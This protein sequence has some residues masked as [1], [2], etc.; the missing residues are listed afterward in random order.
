[1]NITTNRTSCRLTAGA[2]LLAVSAIAS[3]AFA[4]LVNPVPFVTTPPGGPIGFAYAGNKFIGTILDNGTGQNLIYSTDLSGGSVTT[5]A[6]TVTL[7]PTYGLEHYVSASLGGGQGGFPINDVYV[8]SGNNIVHISNNGAINY[9]NFISSSTPLNG[10]VRGITFDATGNWGGNMLVTTLN[11]YVYRVNAT[12]IATQIAYTGEDTEGL[13]VAPLNT[14][15]TGYA[16]QLFV[17]SEGSG[18]IRA[19]KPSNAPG[20]PGTTITSGLTGAEQLSFVPMNLGAS[21]NPLEGMYSANYGVNVLHAPYTDFTTM[22]GDIILTA[23]GLPN[24]GAI[25]QVSPGAIPSVTT[26]GLIPNQPEDGVFVTADM[27]NSPEPASLLLL[28]LAAPA[29]LIRRR[30]RA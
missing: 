24:N 3:P 17:A 9:G 19:I 5:F 29:L 11:G 4:A 15:W 6:P 23:E 2:V 1:M 26:V 22:L 20:S 8:A 28:T 13:D 25:W 10:D 21:G 12:G 14:T 16:G 18:T 7:A 27:I 30:Q